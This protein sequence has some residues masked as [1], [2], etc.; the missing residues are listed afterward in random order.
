MQVHNLHKNI[1][2][3]YS[4]ARTQECLDEYRKIYQKRVETWDK[5]KSEGVTDKLAQEI[6]GISRATY[7]RHKKILEDLKHCKLPPSKKPKNMNK[8]QLGEAQ[9]QAVLKVRLDNPT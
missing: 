9:K 3:L 7:F 6:V 2:K 5:L 1:Y 8:P 4:Y